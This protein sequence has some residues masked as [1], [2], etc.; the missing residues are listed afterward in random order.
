V[1]DDKIIQLDSTTEE[2][3]S[4]HLIFHLPNDTLFEN[5][6]HVGNFVG[7]LIKTIKEKNKGSSTEVVENMGNNF[8]KLNFDEE[9][10]ELFIDGLHVYGKDNKIKNFIDTS[11]YTKNRC[12]RLPFSSK[13]GKTSKLRPLESLNGKNEMFDE[14]WVDKAKE[15][16]RNSL[17]IPISFKDQSEHLKVLEDDSLENA[18]KDRYCDRDGIK[19]KGTKVKPN[20]IKKT[21]LDLR[22]VGNAI[23]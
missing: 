23:S 12:F 15:V 10:A 9:G 8:E 19:S 14:F 21:F 1:D 5:N 17:V 16:L 2:K 22:S 20:K 4:R 6:S 7:K 13:F 11:V 18:K 3:F